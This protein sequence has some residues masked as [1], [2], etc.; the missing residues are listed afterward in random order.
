MA[1]QV[2]G[3]L[4]SE[5]GKK[6]DYSKVDKKFWRYV[7]VPAE[8]ALGDTHSGVTLNGVHYAAGRH[9]LPPQIADEVERILQMANRATLRIVQP[10]R[11]EEAMRRAQFQN[12]LPTE[13]KQ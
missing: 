5:K 6:S 1:E 8:D 11:D 13:S 7:V 3:I 4:I 2:D 9:F 10:R 12:V